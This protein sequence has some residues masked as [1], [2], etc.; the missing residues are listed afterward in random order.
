MT[1]TIAPTMTDAEVLLL[2]ALDEIRDRADR[3]TEDPTL[4][5]HDHHGE[6]V[7]RTIRAE[8]IA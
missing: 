5:G 4:V 6:P 8:R 3:A 1:E 7:H 2:A